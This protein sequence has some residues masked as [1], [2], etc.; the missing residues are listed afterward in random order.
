MNN[1]IK[2]DDIIG[3]NAEKE[4]ARKIIYTINNY[5]SLKDKGIAFPKGLY[6]KGAT[7]CG[8]T[9]FAKAIMNECNVNKVVFQM[10][11]ENV[12]ENIKSCFDKAR[13]NQPCILFFDNLNLLVTNSYKINKDIFEVLLS[14]LNS[15]D[16]SNEVFVLFT[17]NNGGPYFFDPPKPLVRSDRVELVIDLNG[18][19]YDDV[20][21]VTTAWDNVLSKYKQFDQIDRKLISNYDCH[22][23][24]MQKIANGGLI[25]AK[26][27][28]NN[29]ATIRDLES[30]FRDL[31]KYTIIKKASKTEE[32]TYTLDNIAMFIVEYK[33]TGKFM[34]IF[35]EKLVQKP[36]F[37][38]FGPMSDGRTI[39]EIAYTLSPIVL[40]KMVYG[41]ELRHS[42]LFD[43]CKNIIFKNIDN[44]TVLKE[45]YTY[46]YYGYPMT[47]NN[48]H[49]S[50]DK[51]EQYEDIV[52]NLITKGY[53]L[54]EQIIKENLYMYY[55]LKDM[56]MD[57]FASIEDI[58]NYLNKIN[59][60]HI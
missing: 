6:I 33:L 10:N 26:R 9:L 48:W 39:K 59:N 27:K 18:C 41:D 23:F 51:L 45:S 50:D 57:G 19:W 22:P 16:D 52:T 32:D 14:N 24:Y 21:E 49:I 55:D 8:K 20:K 53:N 12:V 17:W 60:N 29:I 43:R 4:E 25:E 7:G 58:N 46:P 15:L 28:G 54:A 30:A 42:D 31:N 40:E 56:F 5:D 34:G 3:Y 38:V 13:E 47:K 1:E 2:I 37:H 44:L 11:D 35:L 36:L